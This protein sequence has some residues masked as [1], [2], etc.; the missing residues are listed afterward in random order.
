MKGRQIISGM[1]TLTVFSA[2]ANSVEKWRNPEVF[3]INKEKA[4]AEFTIHKDRTTALQ[5]L[6]LEN[7]WNGDAYQDLNGEWDFNWY[8][9]VGKVPEDWFELDSTV[10]QW[11]SIP[12]P[13]TWQ[14]YGYDRLYYLNTMLPFFYDFNSKDQ[15][16]R[17]EFKGGAP[18]N[19]EKVIAGYIP[20][21]VNPVGCYRKWI[22]I[23]EEKL[24][25]R[26]ILR[27]GAVEAG[28]S[29]FVNGK[30]VGYS[31]D[32]LTPSEFNIT[33][34][35]KPG[36]NLLALQ[37]YRWTDGSYLEMQDMVRFAG[38]Y[39]DVFLRFEPLQ[40]IRDISFIGT[41]DESLQTI[42]AVYDVDISNHS[43]EELKNAKIDFELIS[44][45]D[46]KTIHSWSQPA[47]A[48][49]PKDSVNIQGQLSLENLKLWSPDQPHLYT[50]LASL[51]DSEEKVLQVIRID[52]G[53]R[54]FED[55]QG[56]FYL[57]NKRFFIKG[58][59][60]HDHHP[61][62][63]RQVT[64]ESMIQDIKLMKQN[65]INTVR[66][67]HYPND[68]RWYY[69]CN[70]YGMALLDEANVESHGVSKIIPQDN[71][72][73]IPQAVD[74][75]VNMVE[76]D[77]N[78]PSILIWS[79]GNEQGVGWAKTFEEQ[80]DITKQ[81]D[82]TRLIMCDRANLSPDK[83][84]WA[85]DNTLRTNRPDTV[86]PM[87]GALE[88]MKEHRKARN[89]HRP[90]FMCEYRHA[91]GNSV[92][93]LKEVWDY[94]Y[95]HE[96]DRLNGGCI[97]DWVDQGV[98][99]KKKDGSIYYQYGGDWNDRKRNRA[100]YSLNGLVMPNREWTPKIAEVKKCYEPF[101][102]APLSLEDGRFEVHNRLN[103]TSLD[104]FTICWELRENGEVVQSGEL[105]T[106]QALPEEKA[107]FTVPYD[108]SKL[109]EEKEYFL[110]IMFQLKN[111]TE[112]AEAGHEVTFSE[113]KISGNFTESI[114]QKAS[115]P[116]ILENNTYIGA[117]TKNGVI[118]LFG[119]SSGA[120]SYLS[121]DGVELLA[122]PDK[123]L[124]YS[125]D[126]NQ[127]KID[128]HYDSE[129]WTLKLKDFTKWQLGKLKQE[130][131]P[132]IKLEKMAD[133][134]SITIQTSY[135][136]PK[137][138]G[139]DEVQTWNIYGSGKIEVIESVTPANG[140]PDDV[141]I[142]RMGLRFQLSKE[143]DQVAYYGLG[144]HDNYCDRSYSAWTSVHKAKV[145]DFF[146]PYGKPQDHGNRE[147]VR[148]LELTDTRGFGLKITAPTPLSM[149]VLPYTQ[150]ELEKARHPIDLP[151]PSVTELRIAAQVSGLGN[152]SCGPVTMEKYRARSAPTEYRFILHP[153][154]GK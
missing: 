40:Q 127:A 132:I 7:P 152:G 63:G 22:D 73:W 101:M 112:W 43:D 16:L 105:E 119:K 151:D 88:K 72:K 60:R 28:I 115:M 117:A 11:D 20:E 48:I 34:Y 142:P 27:I 138:V 5:T 41:P 83:D 110:R 84:L 144:P 10:T 31:Q 8:P 70:R 54:R 96:N 66:T 69:L 46:G 114:I 147:A 90:F 32:S 18:V 23:P 76:R 68:E 62:F 42:H 38:I 125:F 109:N 51:K 19:H 57:N 146:I 44:D 2:T 116:Q 134:V 87:Y 95:K 145:E 153:I 14:T 126:H 58:V 6:D 93:A 137:N 123:R 17:E 26:V 13:G 39:R 21:D 4:H 9:T 45:A 99:G 67:S 129:K 140:L 29:I 24:N 74:R 136:T 59:N 50:L 64:L 108:R 94:I 121:V 12:V 139:F 80:Y 141:W 52:T 75:V 3:R 135:R 92:G 130:S 25:Q 49:T 81:L 89:D 120:L 148:W 30:E 65:N 98:E 100:N 149:S 128:N 104:S 36:K 150:E 79:L 103:Q 124:E 77:K 53:F 143:L 56:N 85:A 82:P 113:F 131:T 154:K 71:P 78:H 107:P 55:R 86:T 118:C 61:K 133:H 15:G 47:P 91:M 122:P 97:W 33:S 35:L 1:L 106:L 111:S 102:I 37:V